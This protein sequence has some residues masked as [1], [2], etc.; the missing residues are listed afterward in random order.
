MEPMLHIDFPIRKECPP[1]A[2]DCKRELL[3]D[4]PA[5]GMAEL[6]ILRLTKEEEKRLIERIEA[7]Q[8][9]DELQRIGLR[10]QQNLGVALKIAPGENEVRTVM[11]LQIELTMRPGLCRKT[12]EAVPAAV[13]R[14]LK[15]NPAIIYAI[16]DAHDLFGAS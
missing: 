12:R 14:C 5:V 11:G 8:S 3:L 9:Y 16:L 15:K 4:D 7:A 6:A 13:R 2:C 1:G 10:L